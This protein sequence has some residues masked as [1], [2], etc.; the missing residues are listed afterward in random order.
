M[1]FHR[2]TRK[3]TIKQPAFL[4]F[5][6]IQ[7]FSVYKTF[8]EHHQSPQQ[9]DEPS[10]CS[11]KTQNCPPVSGSTPSQDVDTHPN[12]WISFI[13][14][15]HAVRLPSWA[16]WSSEISPVLQTPLD[17]VCHG[18]RLQSRLPAQYLLK[19]R[20]EQRHGI[21]RALRL[22]LNRFCQQSL[23]SHTVFF[24]CFLSKTSMLSRVSSPPPALFCLFVCLVD[25]F[26]GTS[27]EYTQT[28]EL[29]V[30]FGGSWSLYC[31]YCLLCTWLWVAFAQW[32]QRRCTCS[33]CPEAWSPVP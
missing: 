6:F 3:A 14:T 23:L 11:L 8:L 18:T 31:Q 27:L 9:P 7:P 16:P 32:E 17:G 1:L 33:V 24:P 19:S 25:S 10:V 4:C 5:Y 21:F 20:E 28:R 30:G 22:D 26:S 13:P 12:E 29:G 15:M 2:L